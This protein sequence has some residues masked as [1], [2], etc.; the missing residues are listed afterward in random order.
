MNAMDR[1]QI[2]EIVNANKGNLATVTTMGTSPTGP[3]VTGTLVGT[4]I[5]INSKGV[6]VKLEDGTVVSRSLSRVAYIEIDDQDMD[7]DTEAEF[8]ADMIDAGVYEDDTNNTDNTL[9]AEL[10]GA[11]TAEL[12]DVF[13]IAAKELRVTLRSLGMGVGKGRRYHLT[14]DQINTVRTALTPTA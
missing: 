11:T 12:A 1:D 2:T 3:V 13:G 9:V 14:A 6:N 4:L 5:S 8:I 7:E 10:D